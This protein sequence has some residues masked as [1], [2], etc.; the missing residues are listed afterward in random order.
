MTTDYDASAPMPDDLRADTLDGLRAMLPAGLTRR[1]RTMILLANVV[2]TWD[3][4]Q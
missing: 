4:R 2:E 3:Q 1:D